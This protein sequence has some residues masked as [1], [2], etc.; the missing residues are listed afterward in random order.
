MKK[1]KRKGK[2][3]KILLFKYHYDESSQDIPIFIQNAFITFEF[4]AY[5]FSKLQIDFYEY[6]SFW[7]KF[8]KMSTTYQFLVSPSFKND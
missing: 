6:F 2:H 1:K 3:Y 5:N 4:Y 7:Y 8:V